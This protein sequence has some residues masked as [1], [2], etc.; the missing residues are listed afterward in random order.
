MFRSAMEKL[1]CPEVTRKEAEST[2]GWDRGWHDYTHTL[3][4][5][6]FEYGVARKLLENKLKGKTIVHLGGNFGIFMLFLQEVKKARAMVVDPKGIAEEVAREFGLRNF[7]KAR[8]QETGLPD[9]SVD[10]LLAKNLLQESYLGQ[11]YGRR[12]RPSI[13][14]E[15]FQGIFSEAA[16]ILK[17][18][19]FFLA[20]GYSPPKHGDPFR[21][22]NSAGLELFREVSKLNY[23]FRKKK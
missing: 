13:M 19:G 18:G 20:T 4:E 9:N 3:K 14:E 15:T 7:V 5:Y 23:I 11:G 22:A 10:F 17:P 16:R 12:D 1:K 21:F 6:S 2:E 8:A